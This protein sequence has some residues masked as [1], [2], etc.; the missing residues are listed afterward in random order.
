MQFGYRKKSLEQK[1]IQRKCNEPVYRNYFLE[2][3]PTRSFTDA[4]NAT[5]GYNAIPAYNRVHRDEM[6]SVRHEVANCNLNNDYDFS[7]DRANA[8]T[9]TG[10][11]GYNE[12][13]NNQEV[14]VGDLNGSDFE[15]KHIQTRVAPKPSTKIYQNQSALVKPTFKQTVLKHGE[16]RKMNHGSTVQKP[17]GRSTIGGRVS[18]D[19]TQSMKIQTE[20]ILEV[21]T[22]GSCR[23]N[24]KPFAIGGVGLHFPNG[25]FPDVSLLYKGREM[26]VCPKTGECLGEKEG[27]GEVTNQR[28]ELS[29]ILVAMQFFSQSPISQTHK[30]RIYTDSDYCINCLTK[31]VIKWEKVGWKTA[32]SAAVKNRD[33]IQP[34]AALMKV[35]N[36]EFAYAEAHTDNTDYV[37]LGN[38]VADRLAIGSTDSAV[39][40]LKAQMVKDGTC[41]NKRYKGRK[42]KFASKPTYK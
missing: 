36:V 39:K 11:Y 12:V 16:V 30:L 40:E 42:K 23:F 6:E 17:I 13:Q 9:Y 21:F 33:I 34:I 35:L 41:T 28:A 2:E 26:V 7:Q 3:E 18:A 14:D 27:S 5:S 25:E 37:S 31:W 1:E 29:A 10:R 19:G 38:A 8:E 24:G 15:K 32:T 4:Y 22:D 20:G